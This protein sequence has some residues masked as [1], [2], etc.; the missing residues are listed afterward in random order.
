MTTTDALNKFKVLEKDHSQ[1][2]PDPISSIKIDRPSA[3]WHNQKTFEENSYME[4]EIKLPTITATNGE[5]DDDLG[6]FT[7]F[8]SFEA[9]QPESH[10]HDSV[11]K[12][13]GGNSEVTMSTN[14]TLLHCSEDDRKDVC[15]ENIYRYQ[16][17]ANKEIQTNGITQNNIITNGYAT[18]GQEE[19]DSGNQSIHRAEAFAKFKMLELVNINSKPPVESKTQPI[20]FRGAQQLPIF[21]A[22]TE[23]NQ[24]KPIEIEMNNTREDRQ[25][26]LRNT[27]T[28]SHVLRPAVTDKSCPAA[29]LVNPSKPLT[30]PLTI[31]FHEVS[32]RTT[33]EP[34]YQVKTNREAPL[35]TT[36]IENH[37]LKFTQNLLPKWKLW[38]QAYLLSEDNITPTRNKISLSTI[39]PIRHS[40]GG[41]IHQAQLTKSALKTTP[42]KFEN[43]SK[44]QDEEKNPVKLLKKPV[45]SYPPVTL[46][47]TKNGLAKF[48]EIEAKA[49]SERTSLGTTV[50]KVRINWI[51]SNI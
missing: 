46:A 11:T 39:S 38:E 44:L 31:P 2:V 34:V 17:I 14:G 28:K 45:S 5:H 22:V 20:V 50:R 19:V 6:P 49:L 13:F 15:D 27:E 36:K 25:W 9:V 37:S 48:K 33:D 3:S 51:V 21:S 1:A 41:A 42:A 35:T 16:D 30:T 29:P 24:N 12:T 47:F 40:T 18:G 32:I 26:M 4:S 7:K 8:Q 23:P 10:A 43:V